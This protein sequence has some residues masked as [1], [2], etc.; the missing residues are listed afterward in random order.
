MPGIDGYEAVKILRDQ[1]YKKPI[2]ALTA[3]AM[4]EER[5]RTLSSGF[6]DHVTK[7]IDS[8]LLVDAILRLT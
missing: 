4:S 5:K 7:P 2:I 6:D 1:G 8:N 3:H